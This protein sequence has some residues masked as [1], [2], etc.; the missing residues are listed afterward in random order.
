[1]S[2]LLISGLILLKEK[3]VER[4]KKM[5]EEKVTCFGHS[6]QEQGHVGKLLVKGD[7]E[8][9]ESLKYRVCYAYLSV[10]GLQSSRQQ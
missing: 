5:R 1:M 8:D 4:E 9:G 7:L 3:M 2:I 10:Q 6:G